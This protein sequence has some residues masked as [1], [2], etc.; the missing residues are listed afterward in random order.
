MLYSFIFI[1][2]HYSLE[3]RDVVIAWMTG[4]LQVTVVDFG[5]LA[6]IDL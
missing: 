3:D 1:G 5:T 6:N 4:S 2:S